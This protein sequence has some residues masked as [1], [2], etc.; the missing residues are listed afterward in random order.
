MKIA[1][2]EKNFHYKSKVL[3]NKANEIIE[4]YLKQGFQLTLRQLYYQFVA[5]GIIPN[6]QKEY[7][8]LGNVISDGRL[9]GYIDWESIVDLTREMSKNSHWNSPK[10]IVA[11]CT[12][13]YQINKWENQP[14]YVEVWVE[15][16]ALSGVIEPTCRALDVPFF[17]CRGYTSISAI[18]EAGRRLRTKAEDSKDCLIIHLGDHDPSGIDMTRDIGKRLAMFMSDGIDEP[19][20]DEEDD[21]FWESFEH[22]NLTINRIA[23]NYNQV[24]QYKPPP[25]P[26]KLTDTRA[27]SYISKHGMQSWELDALE[28]RVLASL[29]TNEILKYRDQELWEEALEKENE[30]KSKL[31]SVLA[32]L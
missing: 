16:D 14:C 22:G 18:W 19:Y 24:Q 10:D 12:T 32:N 4:E 9:A 11:A 31:E 26:A 8:N 6:S 27:A 5:R 7:T 15:K 13:Q 25:N 1:Y 28:P 3:I 20:F 29:I 2:I 30:H 23:L 21:D 17:S